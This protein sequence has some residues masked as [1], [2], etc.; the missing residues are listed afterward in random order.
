MASSSSGD[1]LLSQ[2]QKRQTKHADLQCGCSH[3]GEPT[4]PC[5]LPDRCSPHF[6]EEGGEIQEAK[7][8]SPG[9]LYFWNFHQMSQ[10]YKP[11]Q[12]QNPKRHPTPGGMFF[13]FCFVKFV[14]FIYCVCAHTYFLFI[15]L[16]Y[17]CFSSCMSV[18]QIPT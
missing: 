17:I 13:F 10:T 16:I 5:T 12:S 14:L 7:L 2:W 18:S 15:Y 9:N 6:T 8:T 3:A 11:H 4:L 1:I